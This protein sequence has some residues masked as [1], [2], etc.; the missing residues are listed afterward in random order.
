MWRKAKREWYLRSQKKKVMQRGSSHQESNASEAQSK[1]WPFDL[2]TVEFTGDLE[3][4]M[5]RT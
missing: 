2:A 1:N 3:K 4:S 5:V